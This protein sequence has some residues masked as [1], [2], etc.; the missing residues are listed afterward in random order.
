MCLIAVYLDRTKGAD[1]QLY[2][3]VPCKESDDGARRLGDMLVAQLGLLFSNTVR[4]G[5]KKYGSG[6]QFCYVVD[7]NGKL[8]GPESLEGRKLTKLTEQTKLL[9]IVQP[10]LSVDSF[11]RPELVKQSAKKVSCELFTSNYNPESG[12]G[13]ESAKK[14]EEER[15]LVEKKKKESAIQH[16][17]ASQARAYVTG[18]S[19]Q[20]LLQSSV[21][22]C[23]PAEFWLMLG[24]FHS[25][26][27]LFV[28]HDPVLEPLVSDL[29]HEGATALRL[30]LPQVVAQTSPVQ[31]SQWLSRSAGKLTLI[32]HATS[33]SDDALFLQ[34]RFIDGY[35]YDG[36]IFRHAPL[37]CDHKRSLIL[38]DF[39]QVTLAALT[40]GVI[41]PVL[42]DGT[43]GTNYG[44]NFLLSPPVGE[45][46]KAQQADPL[47][48]PA[49]AKQ[50]PAPFGKIVVGDRDVGTDPQFQGLMS[51]GTRDFF[52]GAGRLQP[53]VP[54]D[55]S[56]LKVMHVDELISFP[57]ASLPCFL[58]ASPELMKAF[59][60]G[61]AKAGEKLPEGAAW[62][63]SIR[64]FGTVSA[65]EKLVADNEKNVVPRM[66]AITARLEAALQALPLPVPV[67]FDGK[68]GSY[69]A[70]LP[71]SVNMQIVD[72][73][74][75]VPKPFGPIVSRKA[76]EKIIA[77]ATTG[78]TLPNSFLSELQDGTN[79]SDFTVWVDADPKKSFATVVRAGNGAKKVQVTGLDG[80]VH[81]VELYL[82]ALLRSLGLTPVFLDDGALHAL[83]GDI[84]CGT[85]ALRAM[86]QE[87]AGLIDKA[88]AALSE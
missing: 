24:D 75:L 15:L 19:S 14:L 35:R 55:T 66:K 58:V 72:R 11:V 20:D 84:H 37:H 46:T 70:Q 1:L 69:A 25:C 23:K 45:P 30:P 63:D 54:I 52:A 56:F 28:M 79:A 76:A 16:I 48:G 65:L 31:R 26:E 81:I 60:E 32:E 41:E 64:P 42:E 10:E 61:I 9:D 88:I 62:I 4:F 67:L 43:N 68:A 49:F 74:V 53:L 13:E 17:A 39:A 83:T 33:R 77:S 8:D 57:L 78:M 12:G 80:Y 51:T 7:P 87:W 71:S 29:I 6:G 18:L 22:G 47:A 50:K 3:L 44:G 73:T 40:T 86:P 82:A 5:F 21:A 34:D 36:K 2:E 38:T 59:L 85:N 27:T